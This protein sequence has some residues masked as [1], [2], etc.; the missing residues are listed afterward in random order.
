LRH[1][2]V[3]ISDRIRTYTPPSTS[4]GD[5]RL[6]AGAASDYATVIECP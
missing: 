3:S 2:P 6:L 1:R 5:T 4:E